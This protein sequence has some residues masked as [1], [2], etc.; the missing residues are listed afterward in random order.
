[1]DG[2][3]G[4]RVPRPLPEIRTAYACQQGSNG[5]SNPSQTLFGGAAHQHLDENLRPQEGTTDPGRDVTAPEFN[6]ERRGKPA[7]QSFAFN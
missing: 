4:Q 2:A 3:L 6:K 1:M 7:R 5:E